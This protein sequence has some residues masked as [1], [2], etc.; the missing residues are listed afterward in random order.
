MRPHFLCGP[1]LDPNCF[2]RL[3]MVFK[4]LPL[5][6]KELTLSPLNKLSS[7]KFLICFSFQRASISLKVSGNV[8]RVSSSLDL[9]ETV[10]Y[11]PSH[12]DPSCLHMGL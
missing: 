4:I 3:S 2:H 12:P 6:G 8:V 11:S 7:A 10:S 5:E 1:H 9:G